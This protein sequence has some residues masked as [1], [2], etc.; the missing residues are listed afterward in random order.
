MTDSHEMSRIRTIQHR[1]DEEVLSTIWCSCR[2]RG[3]GS[4]VRTRILPKLEQMVPH[5]NKQ[6]SNTFPSRHT[7]DFQQALP[8]LHRL[9]QEA[10]VEPQVLT[11]SYVFQQLEERCS[12]SMWWKCKVHGGLLITPKSKTEMHQV[13]RERGDALGI[14]LWQKPSEGG[15]LEFN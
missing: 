4:F 1:R 13:L 8:S 11:Y 14:V 15:F 7:T 2:W 5:W 12:S 6:G 3:H 10:G 9:Q